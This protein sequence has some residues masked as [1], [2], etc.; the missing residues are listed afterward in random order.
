MSLPKAEKLDE[1]LLELQL[2]QSIDPI[3]NYKPSPTQK[4]CM[5]SRARYRWIGGPNRG[6]KT[7]HVAVELAMCARRMHPTRTVTLDGTYLVLAPSREQLQDP[8]EKKLLKDCELR[9]FR[10]RPLIPEW[11]IKKVHYTH[12]AGAPTIKQIEMKN[13]HIIRFAVSKDVDSWKRQQGKA[14][15][16]IFPDESEANVQLMNE[17][18]ARLLDANDDPEIN[19]QAGGGMILWGATQTT[20]NPAL[21]EFVRLCESLEPETND[22]EAFRISPDEAVVGREER[23][24]LK[25]AFSDEDYDVRMMGKAGFADRLLI[26]GKQWN[27]AVHVREADYEPEESDNLYVAYDPGGAGKESH[28]TGIMFAAVNKEQ[29]MKLHIWQYLR[30]NRTTLGYDLKRIAHILR[31]RAIEAFIPDPNTDRADK[32]TGRTLW[33]QIR[34]AMSVEKI[35]SHRGLIHVL[36]RHD[37]GIARTR[38]YLDDG[39]IDFSPSKATG[40]PFARQQIVG[41]RSF[42]P[43]IFQG[44]RGVVKVDDEAPDCLRY[45][46]MA[47]PRWMNRAC[48]RPAWDGAERPPPPKPVPAEPLTPDQQNYQLQLE[49]SAR[50]AAS[51]LRRRL[52]N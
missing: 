45:I 50:M 8:W 31:G 14:V 22:W 18:Y 47:K 4:R 16:G 39:N 1:D 12:G 6:G 44:A 17:W 30:L 28:D 3:L 32:G 25:V 33:Q 35:H 24:R 43:D 36:G 21:G 49:R 19:K 40:C 34:E 52:R 26:Y 41:Y 10:G 13:G 42:E 51:T 7:A 29:P 2:Q 11:E 48:G 38:K 15:L 9:G 27:D 37:P 23:E 5:A 46:V 20:A